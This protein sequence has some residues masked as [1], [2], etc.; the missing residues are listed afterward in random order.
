LSSIEGG[1][2]SRAVRYRLAIFD[3]DGTLADS[4]PWFASVVNQ[5]ADQY[6]FT[7]V[8]EKD[9]ETLRGYGP[10]RLVDA[11]GVPVWKLPLMAYHLRSMM[12]KDIDQISLFDGVDGVLRRLYQA[13]VV[14]AVVS[15]N[16]YENVRRTLGP[17][18]VAMVETF[19]CG[20]SVFGKAS[21]LRGVL[22]KCG[23]SRSQAIYIGD[24]VRDMEAARAARVAAGAVAWGYNTLEALQACRPNEVFA[25]VHDIVQSVIP[26]GEPTGSGLLR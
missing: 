13:G 14:L 16:S 1:D 26:G 3:F 21:K 18:N 4:I 23:I 10:R 22:A 12:S 11:L 9:H 2:V 7:P 17:D 8:R 6:G 19:S 5:L 15:S 25:T 24:E 20:V